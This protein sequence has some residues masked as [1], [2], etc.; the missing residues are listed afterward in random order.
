MQQYF[1]S[2]YKLEAD[3]ILM[4]LIIELIFNSS[5]SFVLCT[6]KTNSPD[7]LLTTRV[8]VLLN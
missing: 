1:E 3:I 2:I 6:C 8:K 5:L 7:N 4:M